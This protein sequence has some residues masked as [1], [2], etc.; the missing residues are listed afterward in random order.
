MLGKACRPLRTKSPV[1]LI[2][3]DMG[4]TQVRAALLLVAAARWTLFHRLGGGIGLYPHLPL[5]LVIKLTGYFFYSF[6][7]IFNKF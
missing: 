1:K 3:S 4:N 6:S 7:V 5:Q 2:S